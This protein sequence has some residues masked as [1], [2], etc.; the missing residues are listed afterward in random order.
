[1]C[2]L[3]KETCEAEEKQFVKFITYERI[4]GEH[5]NLS[6][7]KPKKDL[8]QICERHKTAEN[9]AKNNENYGSHIRPKKDCY[10]AKD[11]D[12]AVLQIPCSNVSPMYYSRKI[13]VYNLT[14]YN[15]AP[16]N[17]AYCYCWSELNGK[18]GSSKIGSC[19]YLHLTKNLPSHVKEVSLWSDTCR[20]QNRNRHVAALLIYV[21]QFSQLE[22]IQ[23]NCLESGH[24]YM[25][26]DSMHSAIEHAKKFVPVYIINDC[27]NIF[28]LARSER[29]KN[30]RALQRS[31]IKVH[32]LLRFESIVK[33]FDQKQIERLGRTHCKLVT[34]QELKVFERKSRRYR[35]QI[36]TRWS[37]QMYQCFWKRKETHIS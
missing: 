6:F 11:K 30:K 20:G 14:I 3:Y 36:H 26:A 18:R 12:K 7:F 1:M 27:L 13:C 32:S 21:V 17:D 25:E 37:V 33:N 31:R 5:Y 9:E 22:T 4:F 2:S 15:S 35:I 28:R 23:H 24:S 19:L 10:I 16:P 29:N 8:C 34:Y